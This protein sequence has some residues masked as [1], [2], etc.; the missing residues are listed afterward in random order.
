MGPE[1]SS[2]QK[3]ILLVEVAQRKAL[4]Y[5]SSFVRPARSTAREVKGAS[6]CLACYFYGNPMSSGKV[7]LAIPGCELAPI[8]AYSPINGRICCRSPIG[9]E[10]NSSDG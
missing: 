10:V 4:A 8:S 7:A 6:S 5:A 1:P 3:V 9:Q 2:I